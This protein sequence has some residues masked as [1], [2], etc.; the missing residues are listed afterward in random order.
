V[1]R[2][3]AAVLAASGWDPR[4]APLPEVIAAARTGAVAGVA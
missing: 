2:Q 4:L 1:V 3:L